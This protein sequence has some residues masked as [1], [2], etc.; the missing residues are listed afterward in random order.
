MSHDHDDRTTHDPSEPQAPAESP[1]P[2][3]GDWPADPPD[4]EACSKAAL[5]AISDAEPNSATESL[6]DGGRGEYETV[7]TV[8]KLRPGEGLGVELNGIEMALFN[9]EG[10]YYAIANR[11]AHQRAPLCKTGH[12]KLN[13]DKCYSPTL[14]LID[15]ETPSVHCPWHLWEWNLHSGENPVTGM[16]IST[17]D[18]RVRDGDVQVRI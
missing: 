8:D 6:P 16:R 12:Q 2:T 7:T 18:V 13:G 10:D 14:G 17:F 1:T 3:D 5:E 4:C 15:D 9:V 11:C